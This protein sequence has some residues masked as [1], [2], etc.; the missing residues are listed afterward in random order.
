MSRLFVLLIVLSS[1][2]AFIPALHTTFFQSDEHTGECPGNGITEWNHI[3]SEGEGFGS[4]YFDMLGVYIYAALQKKTFCTTQWN[5]TS[6]GVPMSDMFRWV[7]GSEFGPQATSQTAPLERHKWDTFDLHSHDQQRIFMEAQ[8]RI[9]GYYFEHTKRH[10]DSLNL[11]GEGNMASENVAWHIRRGDI[12]T[13]AN[14]DGSTRYITNDEISQG[15]ITLCKAYAVHRILFFSEGDETDFQSINDTCVALGVQCVWHLNAPLLAT[16]YSF[17]VA[18][19]LVMAR[20]SFSC[21][22]GFLNK[23]KVLLLPSEYGG[24]PIHP[25]DV[26]TIW[27]RCA[28]LARAGRVLG[29]RSVAP[30]ASGPGTPPSR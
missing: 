17:S 2:I 26:Q 5:H 8:E 27:N 19:I 14:D 9:R 6:R 16:H 22:A 13:E 20:S 28:G 7:G 24:Q 25:L 11:L 3:R 21:T 30:A 23:G 1:K 12:G 29:C 18:D 15:V 10:D 4:I